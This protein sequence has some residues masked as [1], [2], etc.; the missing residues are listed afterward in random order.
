MIILKKIIV[1]SILGLGLA[2]GIFTNV[3]ASDID[4]YSKNSI[5][6]HH[7]EHYNGN[8][9]RHNGRRGHQDHCR[10]DGYHHRDSNEYGG[11]YEGHHRYS[12]EHGSRYE[13]HHRDLDEHEESYERHERHH[14]DLNEYNRDNYLNTDRPCR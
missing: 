6:D 1:P 13:G 5:S 7:M 2:I 11:R 8:H 12:N 4:N 3:Y 14:R 10:L 9:Y